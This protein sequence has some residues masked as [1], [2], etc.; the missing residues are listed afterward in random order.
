MKYRVSH[1]KTSYIRSSFIWLLVLGLLQYH[2]SYCQLFVF[3]Q[4]QGAPMNTTGWNLTG[5]AHVGNVKSSD[6]SELILCTTGTGQTGSIFYNQ[7]I[8]L[9]RCEQWKAEFDFRIFDGT[10][11]DGL[12]FCFLNV[13]PSGFI[14]G[15]GI[16][17][18]AASDGLKIVFDTYNNCLSNPTL[19][20]P[21]IEIRWG[22]G[23]N[24]CDLLP[25]IKSTNGS[26]SFIRSDAYNHAVITYNAGN[27][28]VSVKGVNG[29]ASLTG[30]QKIGLT[31]YLGFT[32]GT[33]GNYDNHSIKN[34]VISTNVP[35]FD[36]GN[37]VAICAGQTTQIGSPDNTLYRYQWT[38]ATGLSSTTDAQP[39]VTI[40]NPSGNNISRRYSVT[41]SLTDGSGCTATDSVTITVKTLSPPS[42]SIRSS[43]LRLCTN[44]APPLF[45]AAA[46]A[47]GTS[48]QYEWMVNGI[49][50]GTNSDTFSV[51]P[52]VNGDVVSCRLTNAES[53]A[54]EKTA[55]SN[56][57]SVPVYPSPT[58]DAGQPVSI[59]YGGFTQLQAATTGDIQSISWIPASGLSNH[60]IT[61]PVASPRRTTLYTVTVQTTDG[62]TASDT[63]QV[64][65]ISKG[66]AVPSAFS[67]NGDGE[68]DV[69]R[70]VVLGSSIV[71]SFSVYNRWGQRIYQSNTQD[72]G[73]DGTVKGKPQPAG[74]YTWI[75]SCTLDTNVPVK[76]SGTVVLIR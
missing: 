66:V 36:A 10:A 29:M 30:F 61:S 21:K 69:F 72:A 38:P 13:P 46:T 45:T 56:S 9:S 6:N 55:V 39:L 3:A 71:Y 4:L 43:A 23:Y 74:T 60:H 75:L 7:P 34:V 62:C 44:D 14:S 35:S 11:A 70:P 41:T 47:E 27:I 64:K 5:N 51:H 22:A 2:N 16:G 8:D 57:I 31:G 24:E 15:E 1:T 26:L 73:W 53:C 49:A 68:N 42:V 59:D 20:V 33:G 40:P 76:K 63:V 12:A 58:V 67:P 18:P 19:E 25:T 65:V 37:D 52:F 32:S 50:S 54:S 17:I 28:S 48:P